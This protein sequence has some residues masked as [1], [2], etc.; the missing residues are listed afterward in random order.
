MTV[1]TCVVRRTKE[2][3]TASKGETAGHQHE[4]VSRFA[5]NLLGHGMARQLCPLNFFTDLL[6]SAFLFLTCNRSNN[7]ERHHPYAIDIFFAEG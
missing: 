4:K 3:T 1:L 7:I 6:S 5:N 2:E